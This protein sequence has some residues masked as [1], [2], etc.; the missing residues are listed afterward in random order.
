M[1]IPAISIEH[2]HV[3]VSVTS[4]GLPV[5]P[6]VRIAVVDDCTG[7]T[8]GDDDWHDADW[9]DGGVR[10]LYLGNLPAG[11]YAVWVRITDAPEIPVR[12]AGVLVLTP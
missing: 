2:I 1:V 12:R 8:P 3:P 11:T 10:W 5:A 4:G 6:T 7:T 9:I